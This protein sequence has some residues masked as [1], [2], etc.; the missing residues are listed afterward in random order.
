MIAEAGRAPWVTG[1]DWNQDPGE[2]RMIG[3]TKATIATEGVATV[4]TGGVLDWSMVS[5]ALANLTE[6]WTDTQAPIAVR[7]PA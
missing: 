7:G 6:A 2:L 5:D 3:H 1:G 4:D